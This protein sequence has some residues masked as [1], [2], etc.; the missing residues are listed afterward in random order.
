MRIGFTFNTTWNT[1]RIT[2]WTQIYIYFEIEYFNI[3]MET[4]RELDTF[5]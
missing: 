1:V 4:S 3:I 2:V 5:Y